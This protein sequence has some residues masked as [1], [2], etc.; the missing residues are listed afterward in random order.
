MSQVKATRAV[1]MQVLSLGLPRTG[2]CSMQAA[3]AILGVNHTYHGFDTFDHPE[4]WEYWERATD[5]KWFGV[6]RPFGRDEYDEFLAHCAGITDIPSFFAEDLVAA[7]PEVC[8]NF[9]FF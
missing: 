7:Y 4:D 5:A 1:P 6:G 8:F 9:G 2:T 3:L